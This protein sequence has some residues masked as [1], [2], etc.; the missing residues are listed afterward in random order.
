MS[1]TI[2][3]H[4]LIQELDARQDDALEQLAQLNARVENLLKEYLQ[5]RS[6]EDEQD[7]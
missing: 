5:S 4:T 1:V 2:D 7:A 3:N 6:A